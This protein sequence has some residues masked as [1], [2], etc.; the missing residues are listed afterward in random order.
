MTRKDEILASFDETGNHPWESLESALKDLTEDEALYQHPCYAELEQ[1]EGYPPSGS[2][3]WHLT[4]LSHCYLHYCD[5][6]RSRPV[7]PEDPPTPEAR[8]LRDAIANVRRYRGDLRSAIAQL[9]EAEF[10]EGVYN[11][12]SLAEFARM[13]IRHDAWHG[14]QIAMARRLYRNRGLDTRLVQPQALN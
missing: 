7:K 12:K 3:M 11:Q 10:E 2:V 5:V 14:G 9:S 13:T 6:V 4:H 1:E 8:S